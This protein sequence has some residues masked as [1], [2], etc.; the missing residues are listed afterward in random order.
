M[1]QNSRLLEAYLFF[2]LIVKMLFVFFLILKI[3]ASRKGDKEKEEKYNNYQ[4][5]LH[6]LFTGSM[7]ILL[8]ILFLPRNKGEVCVD[9]HTKLY[10]FIFGVLS[11]ITLTEDFFHNKEEKSFSKQLFKQIKNQFKKI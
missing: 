2:I 8:I 1:S 7:G 9:G 10:L 4:Q 3:Q 5:K 11:I 6:K